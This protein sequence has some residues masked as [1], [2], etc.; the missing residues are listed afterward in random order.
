MEAKIMKKL[1][2]LCIV[3][4]LVLS[5]LGAVAITNNKT[6]DLKNKTELISISEPV[7]KDAGQYV[8]VSL[9]EAA[10]SFIES[11]KPM[12]P[13]VTKVYT[14]PFGT[15]ISHVDVCF[16]DTKEMTLTKKV[17]PA[18]EPVPVDVKVTNEPV[19]DATT[20]GSSTLYPTISYGYTTGAGLDGT[21]HVIYLSV[22]CYPVRYSP[23]NNVIYYSEEAEIQVTYEEPAN[24]TA[25]SDEYNLVIISPAEFS[26]ALQPL[27]DHKISMGINTILK[28]TEDIYSEYNGRDETEKIKYF[29]KDAIENLG[30]EYVL[31]IGSINKLPIRTSYAGM[32]DEALLIT[33]LYY[34]D[35]YDANG[36]FC[37]WDGNNND[38][39]GEVYHEHHQVYDIDGV[40]LYPDTNIG[41]LPCE[42][43]SELNIVVDKI[44]HYETESLGKSWFKNIILVGGDTF[45]YPDSPGNE[46]EQK[47]QITEQ[48]MSDFTPIQLWTSDNTFNA[49]TL[50]QAINQ[51]AGF[52]DYS[53][54]GVE[55]G[56]GTHPPNSETW[57]SYRN[58]NLVG[59]SNGYKLPIVFFDACLT[60]R[61]DFNVSDLFGA[62]NYEI[63]S[64]P[65]SNPYPLLS[66]QNSDHALS[67]LNSK[68]ALIDKLVPCF[69][70]NFVRKD[71]GGAIATIGATR[72]AFGGIDSGAG[73]I[74]LEFF[75]AY[76][77]SET[78]GQMMTQAQNGYINDVPDDLFTVEEF[79]LI[80]D[81]SLKIEGYQGDE[82]SPSS[83]ISQQSSNP[84]QPQS[85]IISQQANQLIQAITL[86]TI[87]NR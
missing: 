31:L 17:Q 2:P 40:D 43:V 61:L 28:T 8:T 68:V 71:G 64:N 14:F 29:I 63:E 30:V 62:T 34:A 49:R 69:S 74:S 80:G 57:V 47:N 65:T 33:D 10:K 59:A 53:G 82:S 56:I 25:F 45:P 42:K 39:F 79:L 52:I 54:H 78:V 5:G 86:K 12:L 1:L 22:R 72:T 32:W 26:S 73:K 21:E 85:I 51:G 58:A 13:V 41:R 81:P 7:V 55:N 27:I 84:Q 15:K 46:G 48:I 67:V 4:I 38:K 66:M 75:S 23:A 11:D 18:V 36:S 83:Q 16:S 19:M 76:E 60:S 35:I 6:S 9:E 50:N 20:Y 87:T 37:S 3:G 70:W 77:T 44:I 24:P